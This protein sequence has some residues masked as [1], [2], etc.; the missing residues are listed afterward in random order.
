MNLQKLIFQILHFFYPIFK[1]F[2]DKQTYYYLVC[3]GGNT[4][5][6]LLIYFLA[7]H[8]FFHSSNFTVGI[9]TFKSHIASLIV[10]ILITFPIGFLLNRYIVWHDSNLSPYKQL[11]RHFGFVIL[12]SIMNYVLLK[13]FVEYFNWWHFPSQFIT[14]C[15]IVIFSYLT[16]K[17]ISFRKTNH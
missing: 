1:R 12:F 17:Y 9:F 8:L 10:S 3:G 7:D 6:G 2:M 11:Y 4:A 14:T 13:M 15:I 5:L 16:Q